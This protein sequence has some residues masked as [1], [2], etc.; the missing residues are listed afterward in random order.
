[1]LDLPKEPIPKLS[2]CGCGGEAQFIIAH[3][4]DNDHILF[5]H[6][7]V[8]CKKCRVM[9]GT[10][11]HGLTDFFDTPHEAAEAW[12]RLRGVKHGD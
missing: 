6:F 5:P 3:P 11:V 10:T 12:N 9:I 4:N 1:M 2:K 7:G 8:T